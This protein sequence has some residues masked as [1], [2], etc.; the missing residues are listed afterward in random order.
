[1]STGW[2]AIRIFLVSSIFCSIDNMLL[3]LIVTLYFKATDFK[4]LDCLR[5]KEKISLI[6]KWMFISWK[7]SNAFT[8]VIKEG[9]QTGFNSAD[10]ELII[11]ICVSNDFK[12]K[13]QLSDRIL[14]LLTFVLHDVI[15]SATWL[16]KWVMSSIG[17]T[18]KIKIT[19]QI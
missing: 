9:I 2:V 14:Q 11:Q 19:Q 4:K 18:K 16:S 1:M 15:Y 8:Q 17:L 13:Y 6:C 3:Q 7:D 12:C 5:T 10:L